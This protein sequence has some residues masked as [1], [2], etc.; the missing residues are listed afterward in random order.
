[1]NPP[2]TTEQFFEIIEHYNLA[3]WPVQFALNSLAFLAVALLIWRNEYSSRVISAI[4]AILWAW[5]GIAYH[6][7]FFTTINKAA[8]AFGVICLAGASAFVWAGVIKKQ[9]E[10]TST[11]TYRRVLGIMLVV[12]SLGI[13]PIL[14]NLF[15][16]G[17][18]T[19]PT[20]GLPCP[21]TI[22]TI[23]MLCFLATP[24]P[25]YVHFA[26]VLWSVIGVQAA[27]LFGV[28]QDLGLL[29]SGIIGVFL[30]IKPRPV[31]TN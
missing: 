12:F 22:F 23:G 27:F 31:S 6:L 9:L 1:M 8:Y 29:V 24:Y 15:G 11:M 18:P 10:F 4:L 5:T 7:V 21:T 17:Y 30:M 2:F 20:F 13:Y 14:S 26:P 28:Y 16:H 25:R 3:V 19:V